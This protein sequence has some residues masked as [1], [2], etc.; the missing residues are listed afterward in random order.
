MGLWSY[1]VQWDPSH[2]PSGNGG[3]LVPSPFGPNYTQLP[4]LPYERTLIASLGMSLEEYET[5]LK[6][7]A[8]KN[9]VRLF[10]EDELVAGPVLIPVLVSL[11]VGVL[12]S[13]VGALLAPKP[14]QQ[15]QFGSKQGD[16]ANGRNRFGQT[17]GFDSQAELG[18]YGTPIAIHFGQYRDAER[19]EVAKQFQPGD[20][21]D[22]LCGACVRNNIGPIGSGGLV[23]SPQLV[24]SR[25][26]S[27]GRGQLYQGLYVAGERLAASEDAAPKPSL[28]G[29]WIGNNTLDKE[30][31]SNYAVY[32]KGGSDSGHILRENLL[33]GTQ[34]GA[35][36]G[37]PTGKFEP[38]PAPCC[39][40]P[41]EAAFSMSYSLSNQTNFGCYSPIMNGTDRRPA[42]RVISLPKDLEDEGEDQAK[43]ERTKISGGEDRMEGSGRGYGRFMGLTDVNG[44]RVLPSRG[45]V[46]G[47]RQVR[48]GD[49]VRFV[50]LSKEYPDDLYDDGV[51]V[52]D[53]I[54][55][56]EQDR[57]SA[58]D[59]LQIGEEFMIDG[60][61]FRVCARSSNVFEMGEDGS[62][63]DLEC[64]E[65]RYG[66]WIGFTNEDYFEDTIGNKSSSIGVFDS[67]HIPSHWSPLLKCEA[68][69]FRNVRRADITE[70]GLRSR[71]WARMNGMCNF[72]S[73]PTSNE[74]RDDFDKENVSY[75][76]GVQN[77]PFSRFSF[78]TLQVRRPDTTEI[79]NPETFKESGVIFCI[80]G[81]EPVDQYNFIRIKPEFPVQYEYRLYPL[82]S[83][84]AAGRN[85]DPV[86]QYD[87]AWL[88]DTA[89]GNDFS[90]VSQS[91]VGKF[92]IEGKGRL[93]SIHCAQTSPL[94]LG[95]RNG[96][97][98]SSDS[99]CPTNIC[100]GFNGNF[101]GGY[102]GSQGSLGDTC[103]NFFCG[104]DTRTGPVQVSFEAPGFKEGDIARQNRNGD[105]GQNDCSKPYWNI[106]EQCTQI[107]EGSYYSG[108]ISRSCDSGAEHSITYVNESVKVLNQNGFRG[109]N[110]IDY[111]QMTM[112]GLSLR[113]TRQFSTL[114]QPRMW[115]K[116]GINVERLYKGGGEIGDS[117]N[118]SDLIY[119]ALTNERAGVG[120]VVGDEM[121]DKERMITTAKFLEKLGLTF[122]GS[123]SETVNIRSFATQVAPFFLCNF[124]VTNGKFTLWPAIPVDSEGNFKDIKPTIKQIF[125]EGNIIDGSFQLNYLDAD[126]R[127][128]FKASMRYRTIVP[129]E[130]PEEQTLTAHWWTGSYADPTEEFDMTQFASTPEHALIAARYFMW[131]R[132]VVT[133]SIK[134]QT[135]PEVMNGIGPGDFIKLKLETATIQ[136]QKIASVVNSTR[137]L[138]SAEP[139]ENGIHEVDYWIAGMDEPETREV[140]VMDNTVL[141]RDMEGALMSPTARSTGGDCGAMETCYQVESVNLTDDGLCDLV[142]SYY[143]LDPET[144]TS[145]LTNAIFGTTRWSKQDCC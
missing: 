106:W 20:G 44:S 62:W 48:K 75:T 85:P 45:S 10:K 2:Q 52:E 110:A 81:T 95:K 18:V 88:L 133:H 129:F 78:F 25:M 5:Y 70:I 76:N 104:S 111:T 47:M 19:R 103:D 115:I 143:P 134:L 93:I 60:S 107:N 118:F 96:K 130:L 142:A 22:F 86:S 116:G 34:E 39:D 84:W 41:D 97:D 87:V 108:L 7:L 74:L 16:N 131:L 32:W 90:I 57:G 139:W 125:T 144:G 123:L 64:L 101:S 136:R 114:D 51:S 128:P 29:V 145:D 56:S 135:V 137:T 105:V 11:A 109:E 38:F 43:S 138:M 117:N 67:K 126:D 49:T 4:L 83:S 55:E 61:R 100:D 121:V 120:E 23:I 69:S 3:P 58:D 79:S 119:W 112:F 140:T 66:G 8:Q 36:A 72:P 37:N 98:S 94:M 73:I 26:Y 31:E 15:T 13:V 50:I 127:R 9:S 17:Y 46:K 99:W 33:Y 141:E 68:A 132:F 27:L 122:D 12:F 63:A 71:V 65:A 124:T 40:N 35:G 113:A 82:S 92:Q 54:N 14:K 21:E 89:N 80:K 59:A 77:Q 42:W 91:D 1:V 53:L 28:R 30:S 6:W 24:W 102:P